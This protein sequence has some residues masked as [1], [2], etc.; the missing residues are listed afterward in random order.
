MKVLGTASRVV[1]AA[2]I[3]ALL[4]SG[5]VLDA[6]WTL[7]PAL[8]FAHHLAAASTAAVCHDDDD[9]AALITI[10]PD[11]DLF[12]SSAIPN[13]SLALVIQSL[14]GEDLLCSSETAPQK[15]IVGGSDV[16]SGAAGRRGRSAAAA[17][18]VSGETGRRT[19]CS[20]R[21]HDGLMRV[22]VVR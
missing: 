22:R 6:D 15:S 13:L 11:N 16:R 3:V 4:S 19:W 10:C 1:V 2:F 8:E 18:A 7:P 14:S 20:S 21:A 5:L 12:S 9:D 17:V